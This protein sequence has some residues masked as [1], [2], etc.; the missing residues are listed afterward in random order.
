FHVTGVQTCAL[1]ISTELSSR[2]RFTYNVSSVSSLLIVLSPLLRRVRDSFS[3]ARLRCARSIVAESSRF[4][5][6]SDR[7][8]KFWSVGFSSR[9]E[10]RR[11]ARERRVQ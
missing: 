9:S 5:K 7:E 2:F 11:V 10:E 4:F 3:F 8:R 1:P 6:L